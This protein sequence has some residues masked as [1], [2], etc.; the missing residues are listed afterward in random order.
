[1][2]KTLELELELCVCS[3]LVSF[4]FALVAL[5]ENQEHLEFQFQIPNSKII[6]NDPN[7]LL[8]CCCCAENSTY[9]YLLCPS[10]CPMYIFPLT[11]S[12][13]RCCM[14]YVTIQVYVCAVIK[15]VHS[16]VG[17]GEKGRVLC[18]IDYASPTIPYPAIYFLLPVLCRLVEL[19]LC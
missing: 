8:C 1:M 14:K 11:I 15:L 13:C 12:L 16:L 10:V 2:F 18:L 6:A 9:L 3:N 4:L 19:C 7:Q 17:Q 5:R